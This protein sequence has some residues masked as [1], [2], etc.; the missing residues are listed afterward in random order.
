MYVK[1]CKFMSLILGH[2]GA[3]VYRVLCRKTGGPPHERLSIRHFI[4]CILVT[5]YASNH[6]TYLTANQL[7]AESE[8]KTEFEASDNNVRNESLTNLFNYRLDTLWMKQFIK[9]KKRMYQYLL[10]DLSLSMN[11]LWEHSLK[12]TRHHN[13]QVIKTI[14]K[15]TKEYEFPEE[16]M[17]I[18]ALM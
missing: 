14:H 7:W 13:T 10:S 9:I 12:C 17:K 6:K 11:E 3:I 15:S 18:T 2:K 5:F 16:K 1:V 4:S 8:A